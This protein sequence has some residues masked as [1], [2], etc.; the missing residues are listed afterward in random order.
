MQVMRLAQLPTER[1]TQAV[2]VPIFSVHLGLRRWCG[3]QLPPDFE[4]GRAY[5]VVY[6]FRGHH[7]EWLNPHEDNS[8]QRILPVQA[9]EAMQAGEIPPLVLVIP[10]LGSDDRRFHTGAC[11]WLAPHLAP[12][13]PGMGLGKFESHLVEELLPGVEA[14]LGQQQ[15]RRAAI[16][17]S[18]GGLVAFQLAWRRPGLFA[19]VAAYDGSFF[20]DPP[21]PQEAILGHP[22]FDPVFGKPRDPA[23]VK[24]HSPMNLVRQLSDEELG[25]TRYYLQ[26]GP[27]TGEPYDANYDRT[28]ALLA[29]L[30]RRSIQNCAPAVRPDG[31]HNWLTADNFAMDMLRLMFA[32][33][34]AG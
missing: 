1:P 16:G 13:A 2:R 6:V 8:R 11:D 24:A 22:L 27:D 3:V 26:S 19:D 12:G 5:P 14:A 7:S 18:L 29:A 31:H 4:P 28:Q 33:P 10:C 23:A 34:L 9:C 20:H 32:Q 15:P 17:F 25:K 21:D 30:A